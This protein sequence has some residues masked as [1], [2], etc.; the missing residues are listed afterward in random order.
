MNESALDFDLGVSLENTYAQRLTG[1]YVLHQGDLAAQPQLLKF[2]TQLAKSLGLSLEK[3]GD[4]Q[5]ATMLSGGTEPKG[6]KP[7]A[8]AYAGHQF[9]GFSPQLGDGRALL[10]GEVIDEHGERK[11]IHLKG[12]GRTVFSRG[13]DGKAALGPVLREY[14][15][16]EAMHALHVP[17]TRALSVVITGDQVMRERV[18]TG[19][20]L[21]RVAS[22]HLRVGT[23]QFLAARGESQRLKELTDY[24]IQRHFSELHNQPLCYLNFLKVVID[25]QAQLI[26]QWINI[27]FVHGVMNTDNMTI[28]GE[29]IDYGPCAFI[30]TY[31]SDALF[32]SIDRQGRYAYNNQASLA[33]WNLARLAETLLA[34]ID[35][36]EDKAFAMAS[37]AVN[38]FD[39]IYQAYWLEGMRK[40]L[41]LTGENDQDA[42]LA[43]DLLALME[44]H[45]IDFT[46]CFR[47]LTN[48]LKQQQIDDQAKSAAQLLHL[49]DS[50]AI[51]AFDEWQQRWLARIAD[52][53]QTLEQQTQL[54]DSVNP[55]Y[56]PRNHKVEEAL[57]AAENDKDYSYFERLLA[58]VTHPYSQQPNSREYEIGA[59]ADF[60]HYQTF[61][62]T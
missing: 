39:E 35:E 9:G 18:L 36:D 3:V 34:L 52:D 17:T 25:K 50:A 46:L 60:G 13:G 59:P 33:K 51:Q 47:A 30:D 49:D 44:H 55:I 12:S 58:L 56:I 21:G 11:D 61:C 14:L 54:M 8:Q 7:L 6:A 5:M 48:T 40:K 26:A 38:G 62:G 41:G 27:G 32:S 28:C 1:L 16:A 22:S 29:T 53:L 23:F 42:N 20:V 19:A 57:Q 45:Q 15:L 24:A 43:G 37:E 10:L 2:N 4:K 31:Q